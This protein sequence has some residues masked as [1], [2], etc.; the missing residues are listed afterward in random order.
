MATVANMHL[1]EW[2]LAHKKEIETARFEKK[3]PTDED[4][5]NAERVAEIFKELVKKARENGLV[6]PSKDSSR[7][8][9]RH[10]AGF[11]KVRLVDVGE[12]LL[13]ATSFKGCYGEEGGSDASLAKVQMG[14]F[15]GVITRMVER[16]AAVIKEHP[17]LLTVHPKDGYQFPEEDAALKAFMLKTV[18][19]AHLLDVLAEEK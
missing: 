1:L 8:F 16:V 5:G 9:S 14:S 17:A 7:S 10:A 3:P 4:I 13:R 19:G 2:M 6:I 18:N 12:K 11:R 15:G